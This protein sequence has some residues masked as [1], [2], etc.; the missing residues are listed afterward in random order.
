MKSNGIEEKKGV[1]KVKKMTQREVLNANAEDV[2]KMI[3]DGNTY[4][5]IQKKYK[6]GA[7]ELSL[8]IKASEHSARARE[9][10]RSSSNRYADLALQAILDIKEGDDK[11]VITKQRELAHHFRWL[12]RV[13]SPKDYNE[14]R[15]D[16]G[17]LEGKII[18]PTIILQKNNDDF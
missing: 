9:A 4:F 5:Q 18:A 10:Q 6:V 2:I 8:W 7:E 13:K 12:A 14:N 16:I 11:A 17:E 3:Y 1:E 15:I